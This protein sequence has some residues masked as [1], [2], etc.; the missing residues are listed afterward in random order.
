[1]AFNQNEQTNTEF[2]P[3]ILM[4]PE[5]MQKRKKQEKAELLQ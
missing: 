5:K 4:V 1:M 2:E 3:L